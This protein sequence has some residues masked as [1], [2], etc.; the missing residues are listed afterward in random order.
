MSNL[1]N[2]E[3]Y[4]KTRFFG[5]LDGLRCFSIVWV[6]GFHCQLDNTRLF[7]AGAWGVELFFIIS[8]FLITT[9]LLREV[10]ARGAV[11]L[12]NFYARRALRI[13]PLYYATLVLYIALVAALEYGSVREAFFSH[14]PAYVTYTSNWF[15]DRYGAQRVIFAFSW[16]LATEEQFYLLWPSV[17]RF[18]GKGRA[19][20]L[21]LLITLVGAISAQALSFLA[22]LPFGQPGNRIV[23]SVEPTILLGCLLAYAFNDV[24]WFNRLRSWLGAR[25]SAPLAACFTALTYFGLLHAPAEPVFKCALNSTFVFSLLLVVA[26]C[27]IREDHGLAPALRNSTVRYIGAISYGLYLLHMLAMN[28]TKKVST[29]HD[30]QFFGMTLLLAIG[31]ASA[32]YWLFERPLLK[33]KSRFSAGLE[34]EPRRSS[35]HARANTSVA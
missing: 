4:L 16:S 26:T 20:V 30:W 24:R 7:H 9:I 14:L 10:S 31:L 34:S 3:Q 32:S 21:I 8:G 25:W 13:F 35:D 23:A 29:S 6:I 33:L 5:S 12:K 22:L 11:S 1:P 18:A 19:P 27:C 17:L 2:H 15:V 28:F